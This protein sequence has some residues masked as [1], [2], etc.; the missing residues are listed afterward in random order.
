MFVSQLARPLLAWLALA[1]ITAAANSD[2]ISPTTTSK[3]ERPSS[4]T[5]TSSITGIATHTIQVGPKTDPHQ[6][7][8]SEITANVGDLVVFE[9]YPTNHSAVKA[10]F[11]A[12][13]VPA[14]K[15]LFWS[16]I[17]DSFNEE[18]GQLIGP[19]ST[20]MST[21]YKK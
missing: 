15:D 3:P 16:G 18:N 11:D 14:S 6:F 20:T 2:S 9:F 19:V 8:P 4:A 13:C 1:T 17:F 10:D 5:R 21:K 7:V 12:P